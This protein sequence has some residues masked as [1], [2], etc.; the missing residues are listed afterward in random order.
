MKFTESPPSMSQDIQNTKYFTITAD[1]SADISNEEQ[2]V[3][4]LCLVDDG[5]KIHDDF[6]G[7]HPLPNI[8]ADTIVKVILDV[9]LE[10]LYNVRC[11]TWSCHPEKKFK[12]KSLIELCNIWLEN[13]MKIGILEYPCVICLNK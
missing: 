3:I 7:L 10:W 9:N 11:K 1:E 5:F 12:Q 2:L 6:I 13:S 8:K 4:C